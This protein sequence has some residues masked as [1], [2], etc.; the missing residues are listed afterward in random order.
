MV[1]QY[2]MQVHMIVLDKQWIPFDANQVLALWTVRESSEIGCWWILWLQVPKKW[3][4]GIDMMSWMVSLVITI[5]KKILVCVSIDVSV[6]AKKVCS[7]AT[8]LG[9]PLMHKL[10]ITIDEWDKQVKAFID[11]HDTVDW[12]AKKRYIAEVEA[13]ENDNHLPNP[14]LVP[15]CIL[16]WYS[17]TNHS[18]WLAGLSEVEVCMELWQDET[19]EAWEDWTLMHKS[20]VAGFIITA[21]LIETLQ[22]VDFNLSISIIANGCD[23]FYGCSWPQVAP[24][25]TCV[26]NFTFSTKVV[27][28][29]K[30]LVHI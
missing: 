15:S 27:A 1:F 19:C 18:P 11:V 16:Y 21:L 4:K 3:P 20:S 25:H 8:Q 17:C 22:Y 2:G 7:L 10:L 12:V 24:K 6:P 13:W 28:G 30:V 29:L 26:A 14:N 9:N 23:S 5:S